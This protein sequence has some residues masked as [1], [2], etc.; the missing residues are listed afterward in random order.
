MKEFVVW[1]LVIT[2]TT[3]AVCSTTIVLGITV[4][5]VKEE[6]FDVLFGESR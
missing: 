3:I 2:G 6:V 5:Y 1:V 4:R